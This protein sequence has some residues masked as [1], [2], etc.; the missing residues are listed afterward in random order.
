[1]AGCKT[2]QGKLTWSFPF[3]RVATLGERRE[4]YCVGEKKN[5]RE[6]WCERAQK[7]KHL[8]SRES[9]VQCF[10]CSRKR[11]ITSHGHKHISI[12]KTGQNNEINA[13]RSIFKTGYCVSD[14]KTKEGSSIHT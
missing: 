3:E 13:I 1:M 7:T 11:T 14:S 2:W 4:G 12:T 5:E 9:R 10:L 8:P 6:S